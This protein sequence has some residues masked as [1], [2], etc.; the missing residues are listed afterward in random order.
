MP[1]ATQTDRSSP[2][3]S[4]F[5]FRVVTAKQLPFLDSLAAGQYADAHLASRCLLNLHLT[6]TL[7]AIHRRGIGQTNRRITM[8]RASCHHCHAKTGTNTPGG[9]TYRPSGAQDYCRHH[10]P[11]SLSQASLILPPSHDALGSPEHAPRISDRLVLVSIRR[12]VCRRWHDYQPIAWP[13]TAP[14]ISESAISAP[15]PYTI[16]SCVLTYNASSS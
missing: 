8:A 5:H 14:A 2:V 1:L 16:S 15:S 9:A 11:P 3:E 4:A 7:L 10:R 12:G 6:A 13:E